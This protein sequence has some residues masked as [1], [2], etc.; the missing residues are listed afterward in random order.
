[1]HVWFSSYDDD[2]GSFGLKD[3]LGSSIVVSTLWGGAKERKG[4]VF[5]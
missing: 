5:I 4:R 1:M 2:V 3:V